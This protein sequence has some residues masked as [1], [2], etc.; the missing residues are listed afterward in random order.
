MET[1]SSVRIY[2]AK[3]EADVRHWLQQRLNTTEVDLAKLSDMAGLTIAYD[4]SIHVMQPV[5]G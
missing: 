2:S 3:S 1:R 4:T 5:A